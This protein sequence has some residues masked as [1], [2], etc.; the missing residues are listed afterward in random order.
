[1]QAARIRHSID[2]K[3]ETTLQYG[4]PPLIYQKLLQGEAEASLNFWIFCAQL[5]SAGYRRLYDVRE[6]GPN[7]D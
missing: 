1:V 2:L 5:E 6:A 4:A 7:W 3:R